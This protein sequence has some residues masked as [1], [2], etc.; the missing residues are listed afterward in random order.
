MNERTDVGE[1]EEEWFADVLREI[2]SHVEGVEVPRKR[3]IIGGMVESVSATINEE[4]VSRGG[5]VF[6]SPD[7]SEDSRR[8]GRV[9]ALI[10]PGTPPSSPDTA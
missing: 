10:I 7:P 3:F 4:I 9:P 8:G 1:K 6:R 5:G 2:P